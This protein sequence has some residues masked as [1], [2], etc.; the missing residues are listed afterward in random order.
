MAPR[1]YRNSSILTQFGD[2]FFR[3]DEETKVNEEDEDSLDE[4]K[5]Q[6]EVK[7]LEDEEKKAARR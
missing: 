5:L 1:W 4:D 3:N 7:Q 2:F 6:G